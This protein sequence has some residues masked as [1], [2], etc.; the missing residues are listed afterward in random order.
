MNRKQR[1]QNRDTARDLSDSNFEA[2]LPDGLYMGKTRLDLYCY[3]DSCEY[4]M[5]WEGTPEE[6]ADPNTYKMCGGS[7]RCRP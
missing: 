4:R 3:C 1:M 5:E 2:A 7:P 6:F